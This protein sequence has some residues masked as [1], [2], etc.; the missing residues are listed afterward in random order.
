MPRFHFNIFDGHGTLDTD[1]TELRDC[2]AA[3]REGVRLAGMV[4]AGEVDDFLPGEDWK[5][6][7]TDPTG[8]VLF[9]LDVCL[10]QPSAVSWQS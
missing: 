7:V 8:F 4:L 2:Q 1:G 6:E 3:R 9:R 5:L 10:T